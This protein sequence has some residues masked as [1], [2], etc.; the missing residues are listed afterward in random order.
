MLSFLDIRDKLFYPFPSNP[1]PYKNRTNERTKMSYNYLIILALIQGLT[2][3]LPVS[4][5]AHLAVLPRLTGQPDQ[6][7]LI[8]VAVHIG[9]LAAVMLTFATE[10]KQITHGAF[11]IARGRRKTQNAMLAFA[12]FIATIPVVIAGFILQITGLVAVLRS[13]E[14]IAYAM[15]GFGIILYIFDKRPANKTFTNWTLI[16]A[17]KIGLWQ[18]TALIPGASRAGVCITGARGLGY[19]RA[20]SVRIA[21][22]MSIPTI[23]ASG[24]LL[25]GRAI[26]TAD[27]NA[28][29]VAGIAAVLSCIAAMVA[30]AIMTRLLRVVSFTPYVIYRVIFGVGLLVWV[31]LG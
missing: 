17:I 8:D 3:F 4:S 10:V 15:I 18:A 23:I 26:F 29:A 2:E 25:G 11:D 31:Y 7:L 9:T 12:L 13:V 16:D 24:V 1:I 28:L 30:L 6:G 22:V 19:D 27:R 14:I 5:S 20:S 21:M